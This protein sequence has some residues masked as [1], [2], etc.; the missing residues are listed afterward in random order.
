MLNTIYMDNR[1]QGSDLGPVVYYCNLTGDPRTSYKRLAMR[2]G[3]GEATV[4]RLL[5]RLEASGYLTCL[6]FSG[7]QGTV[8]YLSNYLSTMFNSCD[9]PVDKDEVAFTLKLRAKVKQPAGTTKPA[10]S[11]N[12]VS[13][14]PNAVPKEAIRILV[15]KVLE[16]LPLQGFTCCGC[17][18]NASVSR[19]V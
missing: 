14:S 7:S 1:V 18:N 3:I 2:W 11:K 19:D 12:P 5:N 15:S 17:E 4:S 9:V 10:Y 16:T 13:I 8:L 6:T